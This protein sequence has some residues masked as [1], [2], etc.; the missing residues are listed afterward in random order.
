MVQTLLSQPIRGLVSSGSQKRNG[1]RK[2]R[3]ERAR[4]RDETRRWG[5]LERGIGWEKNGWQRFYKRKEDPSWF[6]KHFT[7]R[8][9]HILRCTGSKFV[10]YFKGHLWNFTQNFEPIAFCWLSFLCVIY[11]IFELCL[12]F[13]KYWLD[14]RSFLYSFGPRDVFIV[15]NWHRAMTWNDIFF[16]NFHTL[17]IRIWHKH[18]F[19][20]N[21]THD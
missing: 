9:M 18:Y 10:T 14:W 12:L 2:R 4:E 6:V 21:S 3:E 17:F 1:A 5:K 15:I 7:S 19:V 16:D 11:N 13:L 8:K 20:L